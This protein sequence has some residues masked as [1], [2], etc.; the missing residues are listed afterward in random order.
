MDSFIF[1]CRLLSGTDEWMAPEVILGQSYD[2]SADL[3]S[4]G[5]TM[6]EICLRKRP[7]ARQPEEY[8]EF[9]LKVYFSSLF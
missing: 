2:Q 5:I 9:S 4:F 8:F 3:F 1:K 7:R 6:S